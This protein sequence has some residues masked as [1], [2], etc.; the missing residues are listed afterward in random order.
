MEEK[1]NKDEEFELEENVV[2]LTDDDGKEV[3]FEFLDLVEMDD[4]EYVVLLPVEPL[5]GE[6]ED[7]GAV[8]IL[9]VNHSDDENDENEEYVSIED[10]AEAE[11]VFNI[12]KDK[13]KDE[14]D[15][16]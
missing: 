9:K 7:E 16:E 11:K 3:E 2:V 5:E 4:K 15:F 10:E 1:E 8:V 13:F 12:F 14:Y 6:D